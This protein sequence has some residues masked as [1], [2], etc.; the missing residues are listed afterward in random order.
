[1]AS[2]RRNLQ[3]NLRDTLRSVQTEIVIGN[4]SFGYR[5]VHQRLVRKGV[6]VDRE[7]VRLCLKELDPI[8][9]LNR[10]KNRLKRRKYINKGPLL[11]M[12]P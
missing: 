1:M 9:V 5:K 3:I 2:K 8:G 7:T 12:A 11:P 10:Q 4:G 6:S